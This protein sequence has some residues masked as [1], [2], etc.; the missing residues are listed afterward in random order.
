MRC[1]TFLKRLEK[2]GLQMGPRRFVKLEKGSRSSYGTLMEIK[3]QSAALSVHPV[4]VA[5]CANE[6]IPSLRHRAQTARQEQSIRFPFLY[7]T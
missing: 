4:F 7:P 6:S 2:S 1:A 5:S 3:K